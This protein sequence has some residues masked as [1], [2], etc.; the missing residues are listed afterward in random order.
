MWWFTKATQKFILSRQAVFVLDGISFDSF[1]NRIQYL[2][3]EELAQ[4][5]GVDTR[6]IVVEKFTFKDPDALTITVVVRCTKK[7]VSNCMNEICMQ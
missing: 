5:V 2:L 7:Q 3:L 1:Q 6:A 4:E